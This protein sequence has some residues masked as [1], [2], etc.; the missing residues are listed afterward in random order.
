MIFFQGVYDTLDLFTDSLI[1]AFSQMGMETF[2][3]HASHQEKSKE[4]LLKLL[5]RSDDTAVVTFNNLGYNLDLADGRNIWD[6]YNLSLIH[7]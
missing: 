6:V 2:V 1:E 4:E 7:I 5:E 3:Y